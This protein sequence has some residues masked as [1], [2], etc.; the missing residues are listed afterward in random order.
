MTQRLKRYK[1]LDIKNIAVKKAASCSLFCQCGELF[2]IEAVA[3]QP[4]NRL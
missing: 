2:F 3:D 1:Q 4:Y